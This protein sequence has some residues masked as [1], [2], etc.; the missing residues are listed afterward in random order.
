MA[1][2]RWYVVNVFSGSERKVAESIKE[3]AE[4]KGL[5]DLLLDALAPMEQ[6]IEV[7][8]GVKTQRERHFFPG[9]ILVNM[10]LTDET[11]HLVSSNSKVTGFLGG[12]GKPTP[13]T[14][15]EAERLMGQLKDQK[16]SPKHAVIFEIAEE[17][18]VVDG[19]FASFNG[20]VEEI[21]EEKERLKVS[22]LIFGR[23]TPV[24]LEFSQ[25]EKI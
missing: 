19:P 18:R 4:K 17:I 12:R 24:E 7:K 13:I 25:V 8:R 21:D 20:F 11:W 15:A 16:D 3:Q 6:I 2:A 23:A 10:V 22:V 9:Y 1:N 14:N 5:Q